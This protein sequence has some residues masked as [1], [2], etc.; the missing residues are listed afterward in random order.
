MSA[1][2]PKKLSAALAIMVGRCLKMLSITHASYS[3]PAD[4]DIIVTRALSVCGFLS[5]C[6]IPSPDVRTKATSPGREVSFF[7]WHKCQRWSKAWTFMM[8]SRHFRESNRSDTTK[9][10]ESTGAT[11]TDVVVRFVR[12]HFECI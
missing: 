8:C 11:K 6:K 5:L 3:C 9:K 4:S 12:F 2:T 1:N 10:Y 7:V